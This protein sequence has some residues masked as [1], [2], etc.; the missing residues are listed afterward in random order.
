MNKQEA[1]KVIAEYVKPIFGFALKRCSTQE[2][3]E[4]LSQE[5]VLK[6]YKSLLIKENI[7]DVG[8][9]IWTIA[10]NAL[11]NYYRDNAKVK[12]GVPIETMAETLA[13]PKG[14]FEEDEDQEII[15][16]LQKEIAY[17]SKLQRR[18]VI[19]YYFEN[20]KQAEIA[21]ELQ[22]PVGTVK[23]HLFEAKKELKRGMEKMREA[24]ELKFNPIK[25]DSWGF[26]G[27]LGTKSP[28]EYL[29][30]AID[31]NICYLVR[32]EAKTIEEIADALGVSPVFVEGEAEF[33]EEYGLLLLQKDK[34]IANFII[35]EPTEELLT[36][37]ENMYEQAAELFVNDLYEELMSSGIL[38]D[39]RIVCGQTVDK[40]EG[41][42]P[43]KD[44]NFLLWSLIPYIIA[45]SGEKQTTEIPF[46][47]V[48]TIR[49]DGA[50]NIYSASVMPQ[51]LKMP[52]NYLDMK[53]WFGPMWNGNE[54]QMV[55]QLDTEWSN[56][57]KPLERNPQEEHP[58]VM[59]LYDFEQKNVL[60]QADY[61]WLAERGYV[62]ISGNYGQDFKSTWQIVILK[63]KEIREKLIGLGEALQ[64]KY[65]DKFEALK[66]PY[67]EAR[68]AATPAHLEKI[69]RHNLQYVFHSDGRF[70]L[71]CYHVLLKNGKLK[72][73]TEAQRKALST[74]LCVEC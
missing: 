70:L 45:W 52:E 50:E 12:I 9:F 30:S 56:R 14:L 21:Q 19:A 24:S 32:K 35:E 33:L 61:A 34:Y 47:E 4:D 3:A 59:N 11:S 13:D 69:C 6:A 73:P 74:V 44:T 57:E 25:F 5:I 15:N 8:K 7:Q 53:D 55:W 41:G 51:N 20:R 10:H 42:A 36:L 58:R 29:R 26:S 40:P 38:E 16:R 1:E 63:N 72:L 67:V 71:H 2:D 27:S 54:R 46:A 60:S 17:L 23:W 62:K 31:Q 64:E 66:A 48:A 39:E 43:Q 18:I 65:E 28:D 68:L 22:V 49:P 37:Q